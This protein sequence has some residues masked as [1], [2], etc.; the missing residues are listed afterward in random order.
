MAPKSEALLGKKKI[1]KVSLDEPT[2]NFAIRN[3]WK[4]VI[5]EEQGDARAWG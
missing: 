3:I 2:Q 5:L 4:T 1:A